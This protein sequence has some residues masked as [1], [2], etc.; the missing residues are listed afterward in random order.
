MVYCRTDAYMAC[1][2]QK[3]RSLQSGEN[4]QQ[5]REDSVKVLHA[6]FTA[7]QT[8]LCELRFLL[9][10]LSMLCGEARLPHIYLATSLQKMGSL[11]DMRL[12]AHSIMP[13]KKRLLTLFLSST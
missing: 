6:P 9:S 1:P 2:F 7:A 8:Y 13:Q 3:Y 12:P 4:V 5:N 10:L 11:A